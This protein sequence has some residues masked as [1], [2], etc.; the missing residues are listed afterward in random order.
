MFQLSEQ[1]AHVGV[2]TEKLEKEGREKAELSAQLLEV[3]GQL[4]A[5]DREVTMVRRR[6]IWLQTT[7]G[8]ALLTI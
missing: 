3:K 4:R 1:A 6:D 8:V 7:S 5:C 2:L